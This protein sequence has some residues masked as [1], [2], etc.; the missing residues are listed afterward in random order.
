MTQ[1]EHLNSPLQLYHI[2]QNTVF[3]GLLVT[4]AL[5][6]CET[7]PLSEPLPPVEPLLP[8]ALLPLSERLLL[9]VFLPPIEFL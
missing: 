1:S 9:F 8:S 3:D 7:L 5:L 6:L 4:S 2:F